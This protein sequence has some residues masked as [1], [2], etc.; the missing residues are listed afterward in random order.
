MD[1]ARIRLHAL[2]DAIETRDKWVPLLF[3]EFAYLQLRML[4]ETVAVGCLIAHGDIKD[5]TALGTWRVPEIIKKLEQLGAS[6]YPTGIRIE[7]TPVGGI[8]VREYKVPQLSKEELIK[9]WEISGGFLHRG[10]FKRFLASSG[11]PINVNVDQI[12]EYGQRLLHL[13]DQHIV[14]SADRKTT[15]VVALSHH[16]AK[17]NALLVIGK[18]P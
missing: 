6:F 13:L 1:E 3:Q 11:K 14:L 16:L 5:R 7:H 17:G 2:R 12:L 18:A 10:S 15:F 4:C 8:N 9:L